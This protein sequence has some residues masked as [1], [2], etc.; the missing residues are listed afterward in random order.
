MFFHISFMTIINNIFLCSLKVSVKSPLFL[1][2]TPPPHPIEAY[3]QRMPPRS[4]API[5]PSGTGG[6]PPPPAYSTPES[7]PAA[8][9]L[10]G[11]LLFGVFSLIVFAL[12]WRYSPINLDIFAAYWSQ[13]AADLIPVFPGFFRTWNANLG[14][15][16]LLAAF[17]MASWTAGRLAI[18]WVFPRRPA[19][20]WGVL[21]SLGLGNG[22]LG[23]ATLAFGL[24]GLL[25]PVVF[26]ALLVAPPLLS[27]P[28]MAMHRG[29]IK[30]PRE[31]A[32]PG[33]QGLSRL[34]W[35]LLGF[36]A[37]TMAANILPAFQP[38]RFYDSLVYHLAVPS[39][40]V[41]LHR[42]CL[43]PETFV[44][45]FPFLQE[46]QYMLFLS[47]GFDIPARLLHWLDGV[48][49]TAV[50]F[51]MARPLVGRTGALLASA[52]FASLPQLRFLQ[53]TAMVELGLTWFSVL[54]V[55]SFMRA[56]DLTGTEPDELENGAGSR[57]AWLFLAAWFLGLAQGT[58]YLGLLISATLFCWLVPALRARHT[59]IRRNTGDAA[60]VFAW[61]AAWT[62]PWLAKNWLFT[63]NPVFPMLVNLF[64]SPWWDAPLQAN[65]MLD[66]TN[67]GSGHGS[68]FIWLAMPVM[69]SIDSPD[70]G[71]FTLNPFFVLF[72]PLL[73]L[74]RKVPRATRFLG[75]WAAAYFAAWALTSQQTRFLM[76]MAPAASVAV[77]YAIIMGPAGRP[78]LAALVWAVAG[79]IFIVSAFGAFQNLSTDTQ[80]AP[81]ISGRLDRRKIL[82]TGLQHYT[83]M[84][85][86]NL[87]MPAGGKLLFLGTDE[88]Y[89]C[90]RPLVCSS[91]Y[92]RCAAGTMSNAAYSPVGLRAE[93]R[94]RRI[95]HILF[96]EPKA[97]QYSVRGMFRWKPET[98][99]R[100][101]S[102]WNEYGK[103]VFQ[104]RGVYLFELA[105]SPLPPAVRKTGMPMC[106]LTPDGLRKV[107]ELITAADLLL[108]GGRYAEA[109]TV[110]SEMTR[111]FPFLSFTHAF[112]G[113]ALA[114]LRRN[115]E[116]I[117]NF[118]T[119]IQLG[120]PPASAYYNL[121]LLYE[122]KGLRD[123]A[124]EAYQAGMTE[125]PVIPQM[126]EKAAEL[127]FTLGKR[128]SSLRIY[129]DLLANDPGNPLY[130]DKVRQLEFFTAE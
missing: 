130:R 59:S 17:E 122:R 83:A 9:P 97:N 70:F 3:N 107:N 65:W 46:M 4:P 53:H 27:L 43:L 1:A 62:G 47:L 80:L 101:I 21:L 38:E 11:G 106:F 104:S 100:F 105:D 25:Y 14:Y 89:Y 58:K 128:D 118:E 12:W 55:H 114:G 88:N 99:A 77:A 33:L 49:C 109:L 93:M 64:P 112:R 26:F 18:A 85:F 15:T 119:A 39:R 66:N 84:E 34:E 31:Q 115:A 24:D 82:D 57:L 74:L 20:L 61:G 8:L 45:N 126:A 95:T 103:L 13:N 69:A 10:I 54:A 76:P 41:G 110:T 40:W 48:L 120:Y 19:G 67:F 22:M 73:A 86:A 16:A 94:R 92:D 116:G 78:R 28:E 90:T 117:R 72:I 36:T 52:V 51:A 32:L 50:V 7:M 68:L 30:L 56:S 129:R 60:L 44:S 91:I 81:F 98:T 108:R 5:V 125:K 113:F 37:I 6:K 123:K 127:S 35:L 121:G 71:S 63:G 96:H 23:T 29:N 124:L 79:W 111:S 102:F 42:V 2:N 87:T 75:W